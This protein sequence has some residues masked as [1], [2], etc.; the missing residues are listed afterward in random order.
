[1]HP[2]PLSPDL[3]LKKA[4]GL[5]CPCT[6]AQLCTG[7]INFFVR[8][9]LDPPCR[10]PWL[11]PWRVPGLDSSPCLAWGC[12]CTLS[13]SAPFL[14]LWDCAWSVTVPTT[15]SAISLVYPLVPPYIILPVALCHEQHTPRGCNLLSVLHQEFTDLKR[16]RNLQAQ[17]N[18]WSFQLLNTMT[19]SNL[20]HLKATI[21]GYHLIMVTSC[22][23]SCPVVLEELSRS[24][25]CHYSC[26]PYTQSHLKGWNVVGACPTFGV[27]SPVENELFQSQ[28]F[29][30]WHL[31]ATINSTKRVKSTIIDN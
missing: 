14:V 31:S 30:G 2:L 13:L 20:F 25:N 21:S 18:V 16:Y 23:W 12:Q 29:S 17:Q 27:N 15:C 6:C 5:C 10:K 28:Y 24:Q 9:M 8:E 1:M 3:S 19:A 4:S 11:V 26:P 7:L 22:G